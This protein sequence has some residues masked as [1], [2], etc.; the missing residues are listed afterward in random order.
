MPFA[1]RYPSSARLL[2]LL[3]MLVV[4]SVSACGFPPQT[5]VTT[6]SSFNVIKPCARQFYPQTT[7]RHAVTQAT[8]DSVYFV[9]GVH[10]YALNAGDGALQ[11]CLL[12]SDEGTYEDQF[13]SIH[14]INPQT[15]AEDWSARVRWNVSTL[16]LAG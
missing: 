16:G 6:V 13:V 8:A 2:P 12:I 4:L 14:A 11:W 1:N 10:L 3:M 5:G 9:S 7:V 15:G